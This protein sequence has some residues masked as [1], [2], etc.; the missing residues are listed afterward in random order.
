MLSLA[1]NIWSSA[2]IFH[3]LQPYDTDTITVQDFYKRNA[4]LNRS[5]T[6][7]TMIVGID[8]RDTYMP[9]SPYMPTTCSG[10]PIMY[11]K[12]RAGFS[13]GE[14]RFD[15]H[16]FLRAAGRQTIHVRSVTFNWIKSNGSHKS[17]TK[18]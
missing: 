15:L 8:Y 6:A 7:K 2:T 5:S 3:I 14:S 11:E 12:K 17:T 10:H 13:L 4:N 9:W 16:C 18:A 1:E